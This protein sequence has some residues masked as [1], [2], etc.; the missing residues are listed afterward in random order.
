MMT[1]NSRLSFAI[2]VLILLTAAALRLYRLDLLPMGLNEQEII[3][4][5]LAENAR[6][7]DIQLFYEVA[8]QGRDVFYPV[9]LAAVTSIIGPGS[10]G[11]H[12]LSAW[13][14]IITVALVYALAKRLYGDTAGLAAMSLMGYTLFAVILGRLAIRETLL[15]ALVAA[16]LLAVALA[17][18][19]YWRL[20]SATTKTSAFAALALLLGAGL[21]L[22]PA[23]LMVALVVL[24]YVA[25]ILLVRRTRTPQMSSYLAFSLLVVAIIALPYIISTIRLPELSGVTRLVNGFS[26]SP[27]P[28]YERILAGFTGLFWRGD[29]SALFNVPG[30]ALID[31]LSTAAIL[32]G[33]VIIVRHWRK[34]RYALAL[35]AAIILLP[36]PLLAPES[37]LQIAYATVL[38]VLALLFGLG[39]AAVV[40]RVQPHWAAR[41]GLTA[42]IVFNFGWTFYDLFYTWPQNEDV[43]AAYQHDLGELAH[44]IDVSAGR[45]PTVICASGVTNLTPQVTLSKGSL[46]GLMINRQNADLRYVDCN[47]GLLFVNGG[48]DV[49][50]VLYTERDMP[51][52]SD[53]VQMWLTQGASIDSPKIS[54]G[55]GVMLDAGET[56]ADLIGRFQTTAPYVFAPEVETASP[57]LAP[58]VSF[59]N[60]LTYLGYEIPTFN[61]RAGDTVTL[62]TYWRIDGALPRD[63]TLFTHVLDDPGAPPVA[64]RDTIA[65]LPVQLRNRDILMQVT[66][67]VLPATMPRG[68]YIISVGAYRTQSSE[69][70]R[71][72]ANGQPRGNRL[73]LFNIEVTN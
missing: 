64:N 56:L 9:T 15:P 49:Q 12:A 21:Y 32:V 69:R 41:A 5:R 23:G 44:Y 7:G 71:V 16:V 35:I 48:D 43:R 60:N 59:E 72:L 57:Q 33:L 66:S 58:P 26:E 47:H 14:S 29:S 27:Q 34:P 36:I 52:T 55:A 31:P 18:P 37:P 19:V 61:Y 67:I 38:P 65:V 24:V 28:F 3:D 25:Y 11:Y 53:A 17:F 2:A 22:H 4:I 73:I 63:L 46:L 8:G 70:L 39:A 40:R 62:V 30:R 20:R 13:I 51:T 50:Q 68:E 6:Q 45:V 10:I 54:D 42:L 1:K